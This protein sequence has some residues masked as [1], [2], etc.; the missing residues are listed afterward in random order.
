MG[1]NTHTQIVLVQCQPRYCTVGKVPRPWDRRCE[2]RIPARTRDFCHLKIVQ[3]GSGANPP[4]NSMCTRA[5][6]RR[7]TILTTHLHLAPRL[8]KSETT[9]PF[10]PTCLHNVDRENITFLGGKYPG[11]IKI[12]AEVSRK[13]LKWTSVKNVSIREGVT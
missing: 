1:E 12:Q 2:V 5:P 9:P 4:S 7:H 3:T 6:Y 11:H 13:I 10:L 8:R